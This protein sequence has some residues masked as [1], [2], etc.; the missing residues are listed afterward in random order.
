MNR[1]GESSALRQF[2]PA[3][4][5]R[6][7]LDSSVPRYCA[8][9]NVW[10]VS[11]G[12]LLLLAEPSSGE[13][14]SVGQ[15]SVTATTLVPAESASASGTAPKSWRYLLYLPAT[16]RSSGAAWPL[17]IYLHGR[18]LRGDDVTEVKRYGL[19]AIVERRRDFPFVVVS[20]QLPSGSWPTKSL[21][22][23]FD[24]V[25]AKYRVDP[26]R[27]YLTGVS[28]GAGAAW[29][30]AAEDPGRFAA[31]APV[32]GSADSRLAS[33]LTN[34]HIWAFHGAKDEI[35]P[36]KDVQ[37]LIEAVQ[38]RGGTALLSID[39]EGSHG[40]VITPVY[41]NENLY[42][43]F[44]RNRRGQPAPAVEPFRPFIRTDPPKPKTAQQRTPR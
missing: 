41:A 21:L 30:V 44:L 20:P 24:E 16:Y 32:C 26:D 38:E 2:A 5:W 7:W 37:P 4:A 19:P 28:L 3:M 10:V 13:Q 31:F 9:L 42:R 34:L 14:G 12:V 23:L 35:T 1:T 17:I 29:Y 15:Q 11:F 6:L 8:G 18:S 43:W 36:L 40:S 33:K 22:A 39:P 27:V 25:M